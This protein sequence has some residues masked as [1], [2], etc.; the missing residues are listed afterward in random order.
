MATRGRPSLDI[1]ENVVALLG[2]APDAQL[3][4]IAKCSTT[5]IAKL[6]RAKG[7][8]TYVVLKEKSGDGEAQNEEYTA[9]KQDMLDNVDTLVTEHKFPESL[10]KAMK[11]ATRSK[12]GWVIPF[13]EYS[14]L[15]ADMLESSG[16]L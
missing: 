3:A 7:I 4:R 6:R 8:D 1:A 12:D 15:L 10:R 14:E 11:A 16:Q 9:E 13:R 5:T 2:K